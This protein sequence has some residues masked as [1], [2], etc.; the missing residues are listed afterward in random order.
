MIENNT[1]LAALNSPVR[2]IKARVELYNGSTLLSTYEHTDRIKS[3]TVDRVG[4]GK[5]FGFGFSQKLNLKLLD[6][7][8][9][10]N[11]TTAT[12]I[13]IYFGAGEEYISTLPFF[14]VTEVH[15]NENTGELSITAY[16]AIYGASNHTASELVLDTYTISAYAAACAA[17]LG[18]TLKVEDEALFSL[19]YDGSANLDGT[20]TIRQVLN[21]IADA[22]QTIYF[23]NSNSE[24]V[25][26]RLD[27]DGQAIFTIGKDKYIK[28]D[29][30][31]N[32]RL[33]A[34]VN[35]NELGDSVTASIDAAGTTQ[36]IRDNPF[37]ELR[38]DVAAI[39]QAAIDALGGLTINQFECDWR[40]NYLLELGDKIDF[41]T[42]DGG[43]VTSFLLDDVLTYDGSLNQK[44]QWKYTSDESETADNPVSLGDA[45]NKTFARV[46]KVN[47]EISLMASDTAE[48][49]ENISS[50]LIN[51]ES[52]S[53]S[54]QSVKEETE[55]T[56]NEVNESISTLTN[57]VDAAVTAEQVQ[58]SI[59]AELANGTSKVITETGF[60]F[61]E[62][63]L[64]VSKTDSEMKTQITEDG[65]TVSKN[66]EVV[67]TAN[68]IGV[69]AVN[70]HATTYL[71]IGTKSRFEDFGDNRTGCFWLGG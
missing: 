65:M 45:L 46:D 29:S 61:D 21:A 50:L 5:F 51:T 14:K 28:L 64:T 26:K 15:R 58:L 37:L 70:L 62:A 38:E 41:I 3:I 52:I 18:L 39:I 10:L 9:E 54:V 34:I 48:N 2:Q 4:E 33:A 63:G 23:I 67:L 8:I 35:T 57:K 32:R 25:F 17:L 31:T 7:E 69:N 13:K 66:E 20:E 71:I 30:S 47:K 6:K 59:Q 36:F 11:I 1:I 68:N 22:T 56:L 49:A 19:S 42:K 43:I 55:T 27:R 53:A 16:D 60:T 40:G 24:L 44:T 12:R